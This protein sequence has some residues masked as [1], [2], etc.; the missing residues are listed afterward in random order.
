MSYR[1]KI[2]STKCGLIAVAAFLM[3]M[4]LCKILF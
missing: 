4:G 2:S 1:S 3:G